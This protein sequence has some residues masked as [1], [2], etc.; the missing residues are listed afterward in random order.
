MIVVF[1]DIILFPWFC[2]YYN[3]SYKSCW[4][5]HQ[6]KGITFHLRTPEPRDVDMDTMMTCFGDLMCGDSTD[7]GVIEVVFVN[8]PEILPRTF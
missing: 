7:T 4:F 2:D 3:V 6:L 5:L 1:S 8:F